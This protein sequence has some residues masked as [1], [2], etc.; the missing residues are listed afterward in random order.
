MNRKLLLLL[1][2]PALS[3][4]PA[5]TSSVGLQVMRPADIGLPDHVMHFIVA[6]RTRPDEAHKNTNVIEG[7]FTGEGIGM[8]KEGSKACLE[9]VKSSLL[10]TPRFTVD[11]ASVSGMKGTGTAKMP[12]ALPWD[13]VIK[14]C[15]ARNADALVVLE[16]FDS[17]SLPYVQ[18]G[19]NG[20]IYN[21]TRVNVLCT[22]RVY[23]AKKKIIL[24]EHTQTSEYIYDGV[25]GGLLDIAIQRQR[26]LEMMRNAGN[27]AGDIYGHRIAP[28]WIWVNRMYYSK[29]S[30]EMKSAA[31][32]VRVNNWDKASEMWKTQ[33]NS[34]KE[35]TAGR[36]HH[37]MALYCEKMGNID[38][39]ISWTEKAYT[40]YGNKSSLRYRD[41]LFFRKQE[42]ERVKQQMKVI[43]EKEK[44]QNGQ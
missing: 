14:I 3:L 40:N 42:I 35:K 43:E 44:Q 17:N 34:S 6:D 10:Q 7:I 22:W 12:P 8:D 32:L 23:D 11:I 38:E 26:K 20:T 1:V 21:R 30:P 5:C 29:G 16:S 13:T 25:I 41:E 39:A 18:P 36:A 4:L 37:N 33:L 31:R 2:F 15:N 28:Q 9:A 19:P 27:A 24:D